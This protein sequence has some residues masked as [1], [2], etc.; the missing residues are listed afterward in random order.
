MGKLVEKSAD[1]LT[2]RL[3][4]EGMAMQMQHILAQPAP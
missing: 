3:E 2:K 4:V 1:L